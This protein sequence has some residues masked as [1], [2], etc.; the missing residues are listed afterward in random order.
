M[1]A[2]WTDRE[3]AAAT[4]GRAQGG[5]WSA[6]GVSIDSRTLAPGDLFIAIRGPNTDGHRYVGE[7]FTAGAAAAMVAEQWR[8]RSRETPLLLVPDT[9]KGLEDLARAARRRSR[10]RVIGVTGSVGKTGTKDALARALAAHGPTAATAGNLNNQW[11]LPL[12]LAR[13]PADSAF[14]VFELG[15]NHPGEIAHLARILRP[16]VAV[17]TT[18]ETAHIGF[19]ESEEAI[20]DA[21]A[22]IFLGMEADGVAVLNRDNRHFARLAAH[23]RRAGLRRIVTFGSHD[24]AELRLLDWRAEGEGGRVVAQIG[25]QRLDYALGLP[26]RHW[27]MNSLAVLA[28]VR[29][30]GVDIESAARCLGSLRPLKGRGARHCVALSGGTVVVI[31]ESYNANPAAMRAA[32]EV[33]DGASPEPGGRRIAVLGDMLELGVESARLHAELAEEVARRRIDLVFTAGPEMAH[34][35]A[36]LPTDRLGGH[37]ERSEDIL[38]AVCDTVRPGDIVMVKGSLGS[39]MAPIVE[40][41]IALGQSG[42]G[43]AE[44]GRPNPGTRHAV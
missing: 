34:L 25:T 30:V 40:A 37:G 27:A 16:E 14:G 5:R 26:G 13:M 31:D 11:G 35:A 39:R 2:V 24:E 44:N 32:L 10:A 41:L 36:A 22:E 1:S 43:S 28:A 33:L 18:V 9:T 38:A 15:M 4:G 21:K 12:S 29:E 42:D 17:I 8:E 3:A 19:F 23:A 20:A 7:A 6:T